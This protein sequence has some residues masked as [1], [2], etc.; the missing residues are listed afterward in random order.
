MLREFMS[1]STS[2]C[3]LCLA[4]G[5]VIIHT[6]GRPDKTDKGE[7]KPQSCVSRVAVFAK[8]LAAVA[9]PH[10]TEEWA[11]KGVGGGEE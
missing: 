10:P 9:T 1:Q 6:N 5:W 3:L 4:Q 11:R 8:P 2:R 7:N